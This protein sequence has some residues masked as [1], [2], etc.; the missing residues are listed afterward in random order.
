MPA[1]DLLL[2]STGPKS[3]PHSV[4]LILSFFMFALL[5]R[6]SSIQQ[7]NFSLP[8]YFRDEALLKKSESSCLKLAIPQSHQ[9][10]PL[11]FVLML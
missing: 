6:I 3:G 2:N 1:S 8:A 11:K 7:S 9:T 5:L 4:N 10:L